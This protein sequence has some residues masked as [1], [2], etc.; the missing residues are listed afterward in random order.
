MIRKTKFIKSPILRQQAEAIGRFIDANP[1]KHT[2][3]FIRGGPYINREIICAGSLHRDEQS[4]VQHIVMTD[5][6]FPMLDEKDCVLEEDSI[7][8]ND[9]ILGMRVHSVRGSGYGKS[10]LSDT[11]NQNFSIGYII[12]NSP[13]PKSSLRDDS[14]DDN[15]KD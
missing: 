1:V 14:W 13:S 3:D 4:H 5:N 8:A 10:M 11:S 15:H 2:H 7:K 12:S 9:L 6:K